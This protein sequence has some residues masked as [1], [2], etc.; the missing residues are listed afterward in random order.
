MARRW[1]RQIHKRGRTIKLN[2]DGKRAIV[3]AASRGLGRASAISLAREGVRV[4]VAAR[5]STARDEL[6]TEIKKFGGSVLPI[7]MDL[8]DPASIGKGVSAA[9][10]ELGGLEIVIG[11][12]PGPLSGPF[13]S[14]DRRSW[15]LAFDSTVHAM[16][17]LSRN[18]IGHLKAAGGGRIVFIT[19]V[20]VK[21]VQPEMV[22]SDATRLALTGLAKTLSLEHAKDN[23]LVNSICP[24]PIATDRYAELI[25]ATKARHGLNEKEAEQIWLNEVPLGR[26]GVPSHFGDLVAVLVSEIS[27]FVTGQAIAVDGGKSRAY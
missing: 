25:E 7:D 27:S 14:I 12:T 23:I 11:N 15:N 18:V 16:A 5:P 21:I 2:L 24:G 19:T 20:G 10:K 6:V 9:A 4:A 13:M 8:L 26:A 3:T 1:R 22:L 17:E